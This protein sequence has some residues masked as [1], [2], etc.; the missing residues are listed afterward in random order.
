MTPA[1]ATSS[2]Y[3]LI[4]NAKKPLG[5][6]VSRQRMAFPTGRV[7]AARALETGDELLI[8]ATSGCFRNPNRGEGLV[9]GH[10]TIT[11]KVEAMETPVSFGDRTFHEG[12]SL[13]MH[14]LTSYREGVRLRDLVP[15]LDVFPNKDAW[16]GRLRRPFLEMPRKDAD[17]IRRE[18]QPMLKPYQVALPL[19][20]A[21]TA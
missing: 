9:M 11:S 19:Y 18:L 2:T 14:G 4:L 8:Y 21:A 13:R 5:W 16:G 7:R 20:L 3:L 6:V 17:L 15:N 12:C 10:A 1:F